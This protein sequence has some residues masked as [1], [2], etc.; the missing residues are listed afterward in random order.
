MNEELLDGR[1]TVD[2][3]L[4]N[5]EGMKLLQLEKPIIAHKEVGNI[6]RADLP[7]KMEI[8]DS[9]RK[10]VQFLDI[11]HDFEG[12]LDLK[13]IEQ[14]FLQQRYAELP[15]PICV[16]G[17]NQVPFNIIKHIKFVDGTKI[18]HNTIIR[19]CQGTPLEID[20]QQKFREGGRAFQYMLEGLGGFQVRYVKLIPAGSGNKVPKETEDHQERV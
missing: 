16:K 19:M 5:T 1:C 10:K 20:Y 14:L 8:T 6:K 4:A 7:A 3:A 11:I 18:P 2:E 9:V 15:P 12:D 17:D 13:V